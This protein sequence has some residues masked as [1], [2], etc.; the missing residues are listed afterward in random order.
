MK[1]TDGLDWYCLRVMK[2]IRKE[3]RGHKAEINAWQIIKIV[4]RVATAYYRNDAELLAALITRNWLEPI[5]SNSY[6]I[7][8][9]K[10]ED[11]KW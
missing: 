8:Y 10:V 5:G 11:L 7:H 4:K 6:A 9:D 3:Y 2:L 1:S